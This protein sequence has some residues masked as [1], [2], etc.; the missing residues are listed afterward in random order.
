MAGEVLGDVRRAR[1]DGA[2]YGVQR[3]VLAGAEGEDGVLLEGQHRRQAC[4]VSTSLSPFFL[5]ESMEMIF[6]IY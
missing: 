4:L 1:G 2:G 5:L 3:R 6:K